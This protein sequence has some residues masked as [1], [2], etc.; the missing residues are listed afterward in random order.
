MILREKNNFIAESTELL[1]FLSLEVLLQSVWE[2]QLPD[3]FPAAIQNRIFR[4]SCRKSPLPHSIF[5][6]PQLNSCP[7]TFRLL[8]LCLA[9]PASHPWCTNCT[10]TRLQMLQS[11][12][13]LQ[14]LLLQPV[15][16]LAHSFTSASLICKIL[17]AGKMNLGLQLQLCFQYIQLLCSPSKS[18]SLISGVPAKL[19]GH[20]GS[21]DGLDDCISCPV[22]WWLDFLSLSPSD[23]GVGSL[24]KSLGYLGCPMGHV[25]T[26]ITHYVFWFLGC[27]VLVFFKN[28]GTW[29]EPVFVTLPTVNY[30]TFAILTDII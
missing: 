10:H 23:L 11:C 13:R 8:W 22:T 14:M 12:L 25:K 9:C 26:S 29:T 17:E 24:L 20:A 7:P 6:L 18:V 30:T 27:S 5:L 15:H 21:Q 2:P 4:Y 1:N 3:G 28:N 19:L 16:V